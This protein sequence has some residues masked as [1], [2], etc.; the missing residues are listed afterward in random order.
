[1]AIRA[2]N[3]AGYSRKFLIMGIVAVG[4]ALWC[5]KDGALTYPELRARGFAEYRAAHPLIK[6]ADPAEFEAQATGEERGK[7][8]QF[9][10]EYGFK[11][12]PEIATQ[13]L[14]AVIAGSIG[15]FLI[16]IP[17]RSR[18]QWIEMDD[19]GQIQTSWGQSFHPDQIEQIDKRKWRKKGIARIKYR[20]GERERLFVVDDFKFL[21][22]PTDAILFELEQRAGIEKISGGP[23]ESHPDEHLDQ[24]T[25]EATPIS[26]DGSPEGG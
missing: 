23:P 25:E 13:F 24:P 22:A 14:I 8:Q 9:A 12:G 18:G 19:A 10:E 21:R 26:A 17:V 7:W 6:Q 11:T 20:D 3:D 1:M 4:F 5:L 16:S 15:L 2:E